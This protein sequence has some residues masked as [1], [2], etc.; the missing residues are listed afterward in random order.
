MTRPELEH[1]IRAAGAIADDGDIVVI[2]SQALLGQFP[3]APA[4]F[5]RSMEADVYPRSWPERSDLVEGGIGE[6]SPFAR[7]FGYYAHGIG[8]ETAILPA[9][10]DERLIRVEN[11]NTRRVR[12][13]CL[14]VHDLAVAKL[15]AGREKDLEFV[16]GLVRLRMAD[17]ETLLGRLESTSLTEEQREVARAR[18]RRFSSG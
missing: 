8:P 11:E 15:A 2:G 13:W 9:G 14:E 3:D 7:E 5:L 10:W 1:I 18:I 12:G 6:G 17:R 4:E 16:A